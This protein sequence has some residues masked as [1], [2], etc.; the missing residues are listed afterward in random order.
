MKK[1]DWKKR[2][3]SLLLAAVMLISMVPG[4]LRPAAVTI[5]E[6]DNPA[7]ADASTLNSWQNFFKLERNQLST[8]NTLR[9]EPILTPSA[10]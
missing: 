6:D 5:D 4:N 8:L 1:L 9:K 3:L 10:K 2:A 7:V